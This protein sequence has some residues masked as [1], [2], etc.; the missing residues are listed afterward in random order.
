MLKSVAPH[1]GVAGMTPEQVLKE[2]LE[3]YASEGSWEGYEKDFGCGRPVWI[4]APAHKD[5]GKLARETLA[6]YHNL[7][8]GETK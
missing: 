8:N 1:S 3:F 5:S 2:V 7:K 6:Y 4:G